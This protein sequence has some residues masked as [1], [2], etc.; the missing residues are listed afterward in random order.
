[1]SAWRQFTKSK[2]I[3][4]FNSKKK[5]VRIPDIL[6]IRKE[7]RGV[8]EKKGNLIKSLRTK[9]VGDKC[10]FLFMSSIANS[11]FSSSKEEH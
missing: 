8:I 10:E 4:V 5:N 6:R 11:D 9:I 3:K 2:D 1:M 7:E